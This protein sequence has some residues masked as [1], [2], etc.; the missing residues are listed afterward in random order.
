MVLGFIGLFHHLGEN[1]FSPFSLANLAGE[2]GLLVCPLE[3]FLEPFVFLFP[4]TTSLDG[5]PQVAKATYDLSRRVV[6]CADAADCICVVPEA[7]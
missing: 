7:M 2:I 4:L 6:H 1:T 5:N 3:E